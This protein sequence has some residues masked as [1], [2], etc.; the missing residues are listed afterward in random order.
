MSGGSRSYDA[1]AASYRALRGIRQE[2]ERHPLVETARGF[3]SDTHNQIVAELDVSGTGELR[4]E[5]TLTVRWFAGERP[6][7]DPQFSFHYGD[8]RAG[9]FGWHHEP[10][11]HVDG[12]GHFQERPAESAEYVYEVY[13]FASTVPT[14][15]VWEVLELLDAELARR[16]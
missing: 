11:P 15:V 12:W 13:T 8:E 7:A 3:P 4:G 14:R 1:A 6:D 5:A 10:N 9:D 16:G 2:L